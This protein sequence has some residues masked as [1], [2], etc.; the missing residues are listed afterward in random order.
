MD[1]SSE[2]CGPTRGERERFSEEREKKRE[3]SSADKMREES[4]G[5]ECLLYAST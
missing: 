3:P 4:E 1:G 2:R 5:G